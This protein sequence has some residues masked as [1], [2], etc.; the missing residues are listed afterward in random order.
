MYMEWRY[1]FVAWQA[2]CVVCGVAWVGGVHV[3]VERGG[4]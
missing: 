1:M 2:V 3:W 4:G